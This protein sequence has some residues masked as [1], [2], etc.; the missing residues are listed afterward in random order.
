MPKKT[1]IHDEALKLPVLIN[2]I[3]TTYHE[4]FKLNTQCTEKE[5]AERL[6]LDNSNFSK[7]KES[8]PRQTYSKI[9]R[10][11]NI[12]EYNYKKGFKPNDVLFRYCNVENWPVVKD[13]ASLM[14]LN[15]VDI[16]TP[17]S[18]VTEAHE[19]ILDE[20]SPAAGIIELEK[21]RSTRT[22]E[23]FIVV[24]GAGAS[25]ASTGGVLPLAEK[26]ME[27]LK[28][29]ID[30]HDEDFF[31]KL[32][33]KELD[34]LKLVARSNTNDFESLLYAASKFDR[35]FVLEAL[36]KIC[37]NR[38]CPALSYEILAHLFKHRLVDIIINFNYDELL[39][40]AIEEEIASGDYYY[41]YSG[42]QCPNSYQDILVDNRL[43]LPVYIKPH[44]TISHV[45]SLRYTREHSFSMAPEI[46]STVLDL[47]NAEII[48][49]QE[50][51]NLPINLIIIGFSFNSY[52]F[53]SMIQKYLHDFPG[54]KLKFW[55][56]DKDTNLKELVN[57]FGKVKKEDVDLNFFDLNMVPDLSVILRAIWKNIESSFKKPFKPRGIQRHLL[58]DKLLGGYQKSLLTQFSNGSNLVNYYKDRFFIELTLGLLQSDGILNSGQFLEERIGKYFHLY[59]N[60]LSA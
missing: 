5:I 36:Q 25:H 7:S 45:S 12:E 6:G 34:R 49:N 20:K 1:V 56:F 41:I 48:Y 3:K 10:A 14:A 23:R 35:D 17:F 50:K 54:R 57:N 4:E 58:V 16:S 52:E 2:F 28:N 11:F 31:K 24:T 26:A 8:N 40:N 13:L 33:Y 22:R 44:G 9:L 39:D 29:E 30:G 37:G 15:L 19:F 59:M 55:I 38:H 42:A 32:V 18:G 60:Q 46:R 51:F 27:I 53:N 43:R 21:R 47:L